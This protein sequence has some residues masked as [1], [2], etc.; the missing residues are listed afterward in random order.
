MTVLSRM[1]GMFSGSL[2]GMLITRIP[3][4]WVSKERKLSER[5]GKG[6]IAVVRIPWVK[7]CFCCG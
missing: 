6:D 2:G 5:V 1:T 4:L 7:K 3:A